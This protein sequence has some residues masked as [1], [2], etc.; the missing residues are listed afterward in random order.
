M[1]A[2]IVS[3]SINGKELV[4]YLESAL[5]TISHLKSTSDVLLLP[6]VYSKQIDFL[7]AYTLPICTTLISN[8]LR[9]KIIAGNDFSYAA[10]SENVAILPTMVLFDN[11]ILSNVFSS[12]ESW[13]S[14][15]IHG[16][17]IISY[18]IFTNDLVNLEKITITGNIEEVSEYFLK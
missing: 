6:D 1:P 11:T 10:A 14:K 3:S 2:S 9:A 15:N 12:F 8:G 17:M 5:D 4:S 18:I 16:S 13:L 7:N